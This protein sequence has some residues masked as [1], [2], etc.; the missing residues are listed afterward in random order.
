MKSIYSDPPP[1]AH[2]RHFH[3]LS[4]RKKHLPM[5]AVLLVLGLILSW[6]AF[7]FPAFTTFD[8]LNN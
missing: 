5:I 6:V 7:F 8:S 1:H 4:W 2:T 3:P